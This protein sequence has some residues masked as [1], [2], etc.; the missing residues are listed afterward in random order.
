VTVVMAGILSECRPQVPFVVDE[1][2]VGASARAVRTH[3]SA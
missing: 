2:P 3:R 1:H